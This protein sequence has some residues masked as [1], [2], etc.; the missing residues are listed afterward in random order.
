VPLRT[1]Y[2]GNNFLKKNIY[3]FPNYAYR[4]M[5]SLFSLRNSTNFF[6]VYKFNKA[7]KKGWKN[8]HYY[9]DYP[10]TFDFIQE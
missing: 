6:A 5:R 3:S 4:L 8:S 9:Q 7:L 10:D 1:I 2:I